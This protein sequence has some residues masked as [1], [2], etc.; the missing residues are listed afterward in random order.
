MADRAP[1]GLA[2]VG[3]ELRHVRIAL[4]RD[5]VAPAAE[6]QRRGR[7]DAELR[8]LLRHRPK[9]RKMVSHDRLRAAQLPRDRGHRRDVLRLEIH[10]GR[11]AK[12]DSLDL[13]REIEV[14]EIAPVLAVGDRLEPDRLLLRHHLAD[15]AVLDRGELAGRQLPG[16]RLGARRDQLG[17]PEKTSY[18]VG[19]E[20]R[21]AHALRPLPSSPARI[22]RSRSS[23]PPMSTPF[24]NTIGNVVQPVQSL[25]GSRLRYWLK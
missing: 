3:P 7:W 21:A 22:S 17:R 4:A 2:R 5:R 12:H 14:P 8:R 16:L 6:V 10:P 19:A 18:L 15:T 1:P 25:S 23:A 24:T 9:E 13:L 11:R 20:R